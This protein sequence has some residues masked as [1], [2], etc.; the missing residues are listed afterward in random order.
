M[1]ADDVLRLYD[2]EAARA[3]LGM[4]ER[5]WTELVPPA[6]DLLCDL[7]QLDRRAV[8]LRMLDDLP[9]E[10]VARRLEIA[11]GAA[12]TRVH[13][14]LHALAVRMRGSLA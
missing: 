10:E 3:K 2:A 13:R 12:R 14:A 5:D 7:G 1:D 9:Y 8:E 11:P 6:E 4:P